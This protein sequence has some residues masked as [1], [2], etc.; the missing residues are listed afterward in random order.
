LDYEFNRHNQ[1]P[2]YPWLFGTLVT[3]CGL[4]S[5]TLGALVTRKLRVSYGNAALYV[6]SAG[7]LFSIPFICGLV[8]TSTIPGI[9]RDVAFS[10]SMICLGLSYLFAEVWGGVCSVFYNNII[11]R[12]FSGMSFS[13][14]FS[15]M[16]LIGASGPEL[17]SKFPLYKNETIGDKEYMIP[18]RLLLTIA[19]STAYL[20]SATLWLLV[21]WLVA[22]KK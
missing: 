2:Y 6:S 18:S 8:Y 7:V 12:Q 15:F 20:L 10:I 14:Y 1:R 5:V 21:A 13:L 9:S 19:I 11:D 4:S 3:T 16:T 17:V 22:K